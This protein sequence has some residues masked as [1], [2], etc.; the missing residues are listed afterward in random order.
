MKTVRTIVKERMRQLGWNP[1]K[2]AKAVDGKVTRQTVYN[3]VMHGKDMKT[4]ALSHVLAALGLEIREA[5]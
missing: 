4:T 3:F 2:L 1:Y 5:K